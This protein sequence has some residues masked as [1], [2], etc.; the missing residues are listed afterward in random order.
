MKFL[1]Y[2]LLPFCL[3]AFVV[4]TTNAQKDSSFVLTK[5][6][7][8]EFAYFTV[9]NLNNIYLVNNS[10][11]L[12]KLNSNGDSVGVFN[13]VRKY[14]KLTSIDATNPLKLLLYYQNFS[15]IVVLDRFLNKRNTINLRRENIFKVKAIT[16]SY[17]G[18]IWLFDEGDGKLKKIDD[19]GDVLSETI[20][21]RQIFDTLPA[22]EKIIDRDN[23]VYLYDRNKGF[24]IFDYYGALKSNIPFLHWKNVEVF[25]KDLYGF[26]DT[27]LYKY[28]LES[29]NLKEYALPASFSN[30]S[31]IEI[32]NNKVYLLKRDGLEIYKVQ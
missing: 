15:T 5:I 29:L 1:L 12:K 27:C 2:L 26:G 25:N 21:F 14:G 23:F 30:T 18:N 28:P 11:Q 13:D 19:N 10:N 32:E 6:I 24:Y 3:C 20:D 9:D 22:P 16:T 4:K 8:G 31:E 17:D 7:P